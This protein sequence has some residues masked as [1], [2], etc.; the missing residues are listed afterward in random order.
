MSHDSDTPQAPGLVEESALAVGHGRGVVPGGD[1]LV[2]HDSTLK[3]ITSDLADGHGITPSPVAASTD[4]GKPT[5]GPEG[6]PEERTPYPIELDPAARTRT[7]PPVPENPANHRPPDAA[8]KQQT[9]APLFQVAHEKTPAPATRTAQTPLAKPYDGA[10]PTEFFTADATP[11]APVAPL[12]GRSVGAAPVGD[13][14]EVQGSDAEIS[15]DAVELLPSAGEEM[16]LAE[17][18]A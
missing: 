1:T 7:P 5:N 8:S 3:W 4:K 14:E 2:E 10:T 16:G 6:I 13:V 11:P 12:P 17:A 15:A 9:P 18:P